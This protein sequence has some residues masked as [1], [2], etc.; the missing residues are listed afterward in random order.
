[1]MR[2][3][4]VTVCYN[5][6]QTIADTIRSVQEQDYPF[7]EH[8]VID[9]GSTDGTVDVLRSCMGATSKWMSEADNGIY[10]AMNKGIAMATGDVIGILNADDML[11]TRT[12]VSTVVRNLEQSGAQ[13]VIGDVVLVDRYRTNRVVRYYRANH[14]SPNDLTWGMM[15]PHATFYACRKLFDLY[16]NYRTDYRIAGDF[17]FLTRLLFVNKVSFHYVPST[18]VRMRMGGISTHGLR[19]MLLLQR[20]VRRACI[21]NGLR[22]S[23]LKLYGRYLRKAWQLVQRPQ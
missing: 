20:E 9:G 5:A 15:P 13:S 23:A 6:R 3:S 21:E 11:A 12:T 7:I 2:V 19:E 1:M 16:G 17:E 14:F 4:I 8:L 10:D 18:L 22:P